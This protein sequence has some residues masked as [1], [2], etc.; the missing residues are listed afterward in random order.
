MIK[1]LEKLPQDAYLDFKMNAWTMEEG[2][3][4]VYGDAI[5]SHEETRDYIGNI[6]I[7]TITVTL[8]Y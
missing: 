1:F 8:T 5:E 3:F 6:T 7:T 4:S 2:D